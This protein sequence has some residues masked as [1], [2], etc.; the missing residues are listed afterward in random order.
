MTDEE[1]SA[2]IE[3]YSITGEPLYQLPLASETSELMKKYFEALKEYEKNPNNP[4]NLIWLGRRTAYLGKYRSAIAVFTKGIKQFPDDA[5][6]YR[7]RG[8]RFITLR[9]FRQAISDFEKAA[10]IVNRKD[11]VVEPDGV[12]NPSGTPI[13]SLHSNIYY[14][15]GLAYYLDGD[16][17]KANLAYRHCL[18]ISDNDDKIVSSAHWLYM[19]L[20]LLNIKYEADMHLQNISNELNIIENHHYY[21][22]ILL[23]KGNKTPEQLLEKARKQGSLGLSTIGYGIANW[24]F[25]NDQKDE[26]KQILEEILKLENWASFGYIAAEVDHKRISDSEKMHLMFD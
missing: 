5:R 7:H 19:T 12:P 4:D 25:Y 10:Q 26:A 14:H 9:L 22:C 16:F 21:D 13:S 23:Y 1:K 11:D 3:G 18:E 8:H 17:A 20:R 2:E 15:L 6:M 24:Y